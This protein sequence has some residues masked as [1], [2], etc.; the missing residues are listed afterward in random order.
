MNDPLHLDFWIEQ[1]ISDVQNDQVGIDLSAF[2]RKLYHL[3][4]I[5]PKKI[6]WTRENFQPL[7]LEFEYTGHNH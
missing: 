1:A 3:A 2:S 7:I 5:Y 4:T 6:A